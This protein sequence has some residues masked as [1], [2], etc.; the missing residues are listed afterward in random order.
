MNV[1]TQ[2]KEIVHYFLKKSILLSPDLLS[3]LNQ[4]ENIAKAYT[5]MQQNDLSKDTL[6]TFLNTRNSKPTLTSKVIIK[7]NCVD[8][9]KKRTLQD[10][11]SFFTSRYQQL[12]KILR[13][14]KELD[15][16]T[17][18]GRALQNKG[19]EKIAIIGIVMDKHLTRNGNYI[20]TLEDQTGSIKVLISINK[21]ELL[22]KAKDIVC[23][24]VIGIT[25]TTGDKIIFSD[26]LV[27]PDVPL[28]KELKKGP[29]EVYA[30]F[31]SDIH[32]GSLDFL[33]EEFNRFIK[34][35]RGEAGNPE[36]RRMASLV[37]YIFIIG[38]LVD[39]VGIYPGQE[40][41]LALVDIKDQ[42][43]AFAKYIQQIPKHIQ[44]LICPGN[45]DAM[46]LA[47]PQLAI[48]P[49]MAEELYALPNVIMVSSPSIINIGST[50]QFSGFDVLMY[51]GYSFDYYASNVESIRNNGGYDRSDL[52]MK[53]LLQR[54]HLAPTHTSTLY[55]PQEID[56]LVISEIP[57]FFVTGHIHKSCVANYRNITMISGSCFQATTAFQE[58]VGHHPEPGRVPVVNLQTR[59]V[60]IMRF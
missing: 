4:E 22:E 36:Q 15:G 32:V 42:Y 53:F 44:I 11:V 47:E 7:Y 31:L 20:I 3:T 54:R 27:Y 51:H 19:R 57:D 55:I 48:Y 26:N 46:R 25:G 28:T 52:I 58:K 50:Q 60:K 2:K 30:V 35:I 5:L 29:E 24:E 6:S 23:D 45:H 10:F 40:E 16:L 37:R 34:W 8:E 17:S 9:P 49:D 21:P 14:R 39:G 13:G 38:D 18:I 33:E 1:Q 12:S 59:A 43:S 41:E 56:Q